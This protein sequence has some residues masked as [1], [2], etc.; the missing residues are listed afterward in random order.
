MA[1]PVRRRCDCGTVGAAA[2]AREE[3]RRFVDDARTC[4]HVVPA[5]VQETALLVVSELVTNAVRHTPGPCTLALAWA[6]GGIDV[7][8][9]DTSPEVPRL[10]AQDVAGAG[11]GFGWRLVNRLAEGVEV[12]PT[13][14]GGKTVHVHL[15]AA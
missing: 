9:T 2:R 14:E 5:V 13:P 12:R 1:H 6:G 4:G 7:D 3:V 11:D 10:R 15:A 8:V